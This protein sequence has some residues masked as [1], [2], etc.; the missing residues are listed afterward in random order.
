MIKLTDQKGQAVYFPVD[1]AFRQIGNETQ[2]KWDGS[3]FTVKES[4][5]EVSQK[6]MDFRMKKLRRTTY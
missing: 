4:H 5:E 1:I 3:L 6:L 2:I